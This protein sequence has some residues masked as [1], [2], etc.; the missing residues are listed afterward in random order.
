VL[1]TN[2]CFQL[3]A[4]AVKQARIDLVEFDPGDREFDSALDFL[5]GGELLQAALATTRVGPKD[6]VK[7]IV[8]QANVRRERRNKHPVAV[9]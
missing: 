6:V 1:D 8:G 7:A 5:R 2:G 3:V 9:A 4:A